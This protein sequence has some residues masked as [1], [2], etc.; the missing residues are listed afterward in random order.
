MTRFVAVTLLALSVAACASAKGGGDGGGIADDGGG[1][2]LTDAAATVDAPPTPLEVDAAPSVDASTCPTQPCDMFEQCGCTG[3][4]V[5]DLDTSMLDTGGTE[6]RSVITA[7]TETS[8]CGS[9]TA[10][11]GGYACIGGRCRRWCDEE[12]DCPG[13]GGRCVIQIVHDSPPVDV[14]GAVV[15]S[16][17]CNPVAAAD[18]GCPATWGCH[19]YSY[20]PDDPANPDGDELYITDCDSAPASGGGTG[21]TCTGSDDCAAGLDCISYTPAGGGSPVTQCRP[22]CICPGGT[23]ASGTCPGGAGSCLSFDPAI[24]LDGVT[25]G[26][27]I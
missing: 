11:A 15:C 4:T 16:A 20:D 10:C 13:E 2:V 6:C 3:G 18:N 14:P 21:T 7:G 24:T 8:T 25:Y 23:C 1:I 9:A 12:D 19:V 27:C 22:S 26:T 17:S 5:C